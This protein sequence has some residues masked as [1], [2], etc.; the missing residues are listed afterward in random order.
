MHRNQQ[1][2]QH[3]QGEAR[4]RQL[5]GQELGFGVGKDKAEQEKSE[6]AVFQGSQGECE[7][8]VT[9]EKNSGGEQFHEQV[10]RRNSGFAVA[11]APAKNQP[12][13]DG[14]VVIEGDGPLTAGAG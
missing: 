11:A 2:E 10:A 9:A 12:T 1:T 5:V 6:D 13:D 14:Q 4:E 8:S 7:I 3:A